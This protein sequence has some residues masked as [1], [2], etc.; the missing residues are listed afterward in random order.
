MGSIANLVYGTRL[1]NEEA[2][3]FFKRVIDVV[4]SFEASAGGG[5]EDVPELMSV[6]AET[7]K[8]EL[9]LTDYLTDLKTSYTEFQSALSV[10]V[11]LV[12][13]AELERI[14]NNRILV[15]GTLKKTIHM[16]KN[17][18]G[19]DASIELWNQ[20]RIVKN[21]HSMNMHKV[22]G[23]IQDLIDELKSEEMAALCKDK[24]IESTL[25]T[26]EEIQ[27]EFE[28][29]YDKRANKVE[30]R[31]IKA[32]PYK[33]ECLAAY[34]KMVEYLNSMVL[35][36]SNTDYQE[37]V[38][39]MNAVVNPM[40]TMLRLRMTKKTEDGSTDDAPVES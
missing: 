38:D 3:I 15:F 29:L 19:D 6:E 32:T 18:V 36:D 26:L 28:A 27:T 23:V 13:T 9:K 22:S 24:D 16:Y 14:N 5:D 4:T 39:S 40:N 10:P 25:T 33:I 30:T 31:V 21:L 1:H 35:Y 2:S 7:T 34:K 20:V 17:T 37:L 11:K 12:E 8:T